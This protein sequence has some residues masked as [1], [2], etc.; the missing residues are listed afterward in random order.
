MKKVNYLL[1]MMM[2]T[3]V[4]VGCNDDDD[5][6][7]LS[8]NQSA[9]EMILNTKEAVK[10]SG[11]ELAY[12]VKATDE[13]IAKAT[14]DKD[15]ITIEALKEG[16]TEITVTD[17][18]KKTG[19][20]RVAVVKPINWTDADAAD[21]TTRIVW[22]SYSKKTGTDAGTYTFTKKA[23]EKT[24]S[25]SWKGSDKESAVLAFTDPKDLIAASS[26]T[27]ASLITA[28]TLVITT[29]GKPTN[30]TISKWVLIQKKSLAENEAATYW[31]AFKANNK[32]GFIVSKLSE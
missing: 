1:L 6:K 13:T 10:V 29:D 27:K 24:V 11:G 4:F 14:V 20:I 25:F 30:Y 18:N 15:V 22:D 26:S 9:T 31:I 7:N 8:F 5:D 3:L 17:K 16:S 21:G 23:A 32:W 28:G 19:K 12:T 2:T